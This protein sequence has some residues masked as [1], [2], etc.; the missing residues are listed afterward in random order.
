MV[1][2]VLGIGIG[3]F[4]ALIFFWHP[5]LSFVLP[6]FIF[7]LLALSKP[8][9]IPSEQRILPSHVPFL[10]KVKSNQKYLWALY[11]V[12]SLFM[13]FNYQGNVLL[14]LG[15]LGGTYILIY[16]L[17][18]MARR[19]SSFSV[20]SLRIGNVGMTMIVIY[21]AVLY[22][23]MFVG[24]G[25]S[26]GRIPGILPI[27][28]TIVIYSVLSWIIHTSRPAAESVEI[29]PLLTANSMKLSDYKKFVYFN[30][31]F[32]SGLCLV[33]LAAPHVMV[34][35]FLCFYL[36]ICVIGVYIFYKAVYS[37]NEQTPESLQNSY[38]K[39]TETLTAELQVLPG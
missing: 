19:Y 10:V 14:V 17:V 27:A 31:L 21:L 6:V 20:Y 28:T 39:L 7:E 34:I 23:F 38:A 13:A 37:R 25:Y 29:P 26:S 32:A 16:L 4:L 9:E 36:L 30:L 18:I 15:A 11:V 2:S 3:E 12:G 33:I 22:A 35:P 1:G 24:Y 8:S 5:I